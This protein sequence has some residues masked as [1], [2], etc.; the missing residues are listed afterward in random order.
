MNFRERVNFCKL[1]LEEQLLVIVSQFSQVVA[2]WRF[3]DQA[4]DLRH[5]IKHRVFAEFL[6]F[7]PSEF[8]AAENVKHSVFNNHEMRIVPQ[9]GRWIIAVVI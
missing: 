9:R 5:F 6:I 2:C 3:Y 7:V 4:F 1:F 8:L